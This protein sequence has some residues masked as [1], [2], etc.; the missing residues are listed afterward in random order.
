[1]VGDDIDAF[2]DENYRGKDEPNRI[3]GSGLTT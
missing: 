1:M 2:N 3:N